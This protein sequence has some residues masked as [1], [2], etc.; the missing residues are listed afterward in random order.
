MPI[1]ITAACSIL[2]V[3]K[4]GEFGVVRGR[5]F[6][7]GGRICEDTHA[8]PLL[9]RQA[10]PLEIGRDVFRGVG[11]RGR[12]QPGAALAFL[13]RFDVQH[14]KRRGYVLCQLTCNQLLSNN[15]AERTKTT[16]PRQLNSVEARH[17]SSLFVPSQGILGDTPGGAR[18]GGRNLGAPKPEECRGW[19]Q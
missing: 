4:R 17:D 2:D 16:R 5:W 3:K 11:S 18:S 15:V 7:N 13:D 10:Q 1:W 12:T 8:V 9:H 19:Q 6:V 14:C